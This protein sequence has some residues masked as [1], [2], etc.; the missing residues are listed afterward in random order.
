LGGRRILSGAE[1][2]NDKPPEI[3]PEFETVCSVLESVAKGF[4]EGSKEA[5]AVEDAAHAYIF[6]QLHLQ[7][8]RVYDEYRKTG[9]RGLTDE[10]EQHLRDM[11]IDVED[12]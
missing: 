9:S 10:Q 7:L 5:K 8:R 1:I 12:C 11:G 4:P 3:N 6:L 2:V